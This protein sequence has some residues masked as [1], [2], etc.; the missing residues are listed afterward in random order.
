MEQEEKTLNQFKRHKLALDLCNETIKLI[1]LDIV[2]IETALEQ[3]YKAKNAD[4][5]RDDLEQNLAKANHNLNQATILRGNIIMQ[6]YDL[7][8]VNYHGRGNNN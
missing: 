6:A 2:T 5:E 3:K 7:I 1:N 8:I 4:N